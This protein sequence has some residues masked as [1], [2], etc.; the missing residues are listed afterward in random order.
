MLLIFS[1]LLLSFYLTPLRPTAAATITIATRNSP[2]SEMFLIFAA[3]WEDEKTRR[4]MNMFLY[5]AAF[6]VPTRS[7]LKYIRTYC[8]YV[9][10]T[11]NVCMCVYGDHSNSWPMAWRCY[12]I[13]LTSH[14]FY[15]HLFHLPPPPRL[16]VPQQKLMCVYLRMYVSTHLSAS[17]PRSES[18][19]VCV[20]L[21]PT[22]LG[23]LLTHTTADR[24]AHALKLIMFAHGPCTN[25]YTYQFV[26]LFV[27][28]HA[29]MCL[30]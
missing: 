1:S 17:A 19:W 6:R 12:M 21:M 22:L 3:K 15:H 9:I 23:H 30:N 8:T 28:L 4:G 27:Y 11:Y 24:N 26:C 16:E 14:C 13:K 29:H 10:Y 18:F 25:V 5:A 7:R 20:L 2:Q